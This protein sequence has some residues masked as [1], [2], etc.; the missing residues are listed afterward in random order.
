MSIFVV[1]VAVAI[2]I[3]LALAFVAGR[4]LLKLSRLRKYQAARLAAQ[5]QANLQAIKAQ[6]ERLNKSIQI[7]AQATHQQELSLTE[8]SMRISVLL[9]NL[10]ISAMVKEE[11]SAFYQLR[12]KTEHI[13][14]LE[15]WQQLSRK[16]QN[17]FDVE[18]LHHESTYSDFVMDAA[19]RILGRTF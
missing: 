2:L 15:A 12:E 10:D 17:A 9:D 18:R 3:V 6:R 4:L 16:E 1:L 14:I 13:P 5:E 19:K 7:I 11:F 8:A